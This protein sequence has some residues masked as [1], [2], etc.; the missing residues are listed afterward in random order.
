VSTE[1]SPRGGYVFDL[2]V[3]ESVEFRGR[4][5]SR[6]KVTLVALHEERDRAR[7]VIR[8]PRVTIDIDGKQTELA[9]A[10]YQMPQIVN[11]VRIDCSL[12]RGIAEALE[13]TRHEILDKDA[14]I[15]CWDPAAP[16][17]DT[18]PLVYPVG[19]IWFASMTQMANERVFVDAGELPVMKPGTAVY[20]HCG[21]DFGGHD[22]AVPV[23]AA[24]SGM[25]VVLGDEELPDYKGD[26]G[27]KRY[28]RVIIRD[29]KGWYYRYSHLDM[30]DPT[31]RLGQPIAAGDPIG[32][33]GKEGASGGWAHLHFSITSL[34]PNG[35]YGEVEGYP[36]LVEAYL[37]KH[38]GALLA[39]ARP[40][41]V[42]LIG[43]E[44]ELDGSRSLC[45]GAEIKSFQWMLH[46]GKICDDVRAKIA[47]EG[48]ACIP[49][50]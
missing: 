28:D 33:L 41:R 9:S 38:P 19:Q 12:T 3:G 49:K 35:R 30:I 17:F 45:D 24:H 13:G 7:G 46:N 25:V 34:Q 4:D 27:T 39:C 23:I 20:H 40:H 36:F 22:R 1:T 11:G 44:I 47:Y 21:M 37:R 43:E 10:H 48:K 15:R 16:L 8:F 50:C 26:G 14:R 31:V 18:V 42:A 2:S 32:V 5:G 6:R 29:E